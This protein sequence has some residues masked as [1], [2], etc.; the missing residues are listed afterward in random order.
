MEKLKGN[1]DLTELEDKYVLIYHGSN[2]IVRNP[3]IRIGK[4]T[5]DFYRGF[6]VPYCKTKQKNGQIEI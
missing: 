6:I 4:F 3:E 2:S 5:K 1:M